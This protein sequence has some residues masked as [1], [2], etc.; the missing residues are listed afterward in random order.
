MLFVSRTTFGPSKSIL[1]NTHATALLRR[2]VQTTS[3]TT[4]ART[5]L[6][7]AQRVQSVVATE[8]IA[9]LGANVGTSMQVSTT[10]ADLEPMSSSLP[11]IVP[12]HEQ[13]HWQPCSIH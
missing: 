2:T 3:W 5:R 8:P 11:K 7:V 12:I 4:T 10:L 9:H 1:S 6:R 13:Q